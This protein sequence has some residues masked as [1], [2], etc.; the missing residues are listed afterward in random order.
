MFN[1]WVLDSSGEVVKHF[2]DCMN[3]SVLSEN[4]MEQSYPDIL[5]AIGFD[6]SYVRLGDSQGYHFYP[7]YVYSVNIGS[8]GA[9]EFI[10]YFK[11]FLG[12]W[13]CL[14]CY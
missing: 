3:I 8:V 11:S 9:N 4:Q 13:Q 10:N 6:S 12:F 2:E 1:A 14:L 5:D 7:L